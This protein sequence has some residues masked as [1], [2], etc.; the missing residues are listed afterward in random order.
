MYSLRPRA[1]LLTASLFL[2]AVPAAI[3]PSA[4]QAATKRERTPDLAAQ[5]SAQFELAYRSY[6]AEGESRQ[7]QLNV[8]VAAWRAAPRTDANNERLNNWLHAAIRASM[9]GSHEPLPAAPSFAANSE[10]EKRA[11]AEPKPATLRAPEPTPANEV[12]RPPKDESHVDPFR[13]DPAD[14]QQTK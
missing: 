8:V 3:L 14:K 12:T 9:P 10:S 5:A 1:A 13:D 7:A 2:L 6:P 4:A 11:V